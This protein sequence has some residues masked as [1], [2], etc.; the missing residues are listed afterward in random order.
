MSETSTPALRS[1]PATTIAIGG[2]MRCCLAHEL[3]VDAPVGTTAPCR[4]CEDGLRLVA[5]PTDGALFWQAAWI[6]LGH[7]WRK[8]DAATDSPAAS[9][10]G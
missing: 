8:T 4:Y 1:S 2:V 3:P 10:R 6:T 9:W 5:D 7:G